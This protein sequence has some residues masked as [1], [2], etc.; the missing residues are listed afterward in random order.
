MSDNDPSD[1]R[2]T[3][4]EH[5]KDFVRTGERSSSDELAG[6][7]GL[8]GF[9]LRGVAGGVGGLALGLAHDVLSPVASRLGRELAGEED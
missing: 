6:S 8:A 7:L 4:L 9:A 3:E 5:V 1:N 2:D